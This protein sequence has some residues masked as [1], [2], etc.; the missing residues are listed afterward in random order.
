MKYPKLKAVIIA[1]DRSVFK[2]GS[3]TLSR[4]LSYAKE[5]K[6]LH[7][8]IFT[9]RNENLKSRK[10]GNLYVYP[11]NSFSQFTYIFDCI[12]GVKK[13]LSRKS[14]S[15]KDLVVS[16][17]DPF[18][19]GLVGL[20]LSKKF[21]LPFQVQIHTDFLDPHFSRNFLNKIRVFLAKITLKQASG[22]RVVSEP[23]ARSL[24]KLKVKRKPDILP[25]FVNVEKFKDTLVNRSLIDPG[26]LFKKNILMNSRLTE[27]KRFDTALSVFK[28]VYERNN[29]VGLIILG[30]GPE[31]E[32]IRNRIAYLG[33]TDRVHFSGKWES[34]NKILVYYKLADVFLL[35]SEF[36][37][38]GLTLVEA[39]A[40]GCP[41]VTTKVGLA[42]TNLF[43]N[44]VNSFVC[45]VDDIVCLAS[46]VLE[47]ISKSQI[48]NLFKS[49]MQD[50]IMSTAIKEDEY[51]QKYA[52]FLACLVQ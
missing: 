2:D 19:T 50:S 44:G 31:E 12:K 24:E 33:L 28:K 4:H 51:A 14:F 38:Y 49:G 47:V 40:S 42:K 26:L 23:I 9:L 27:E 48:A 34:M 13:L 7:L 35:T 29:D 8:F 18:L 36:E 52:Y 37:G 3:P 41:I 1:T 45:E 21:K 6:E 46:S 32:N 22:I 43:R 11:T 10:I 20:F 15:K 5:M 39:G 30:S 25:I 16:T 17:Q